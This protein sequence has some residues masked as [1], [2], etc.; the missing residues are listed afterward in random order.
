M[1]E[2]DAA[3][4]T[5]TSIIGINSRNLNTPEVDIRTF[6]R[7]APVAKDAG[8]FLVAWSGVHSRK[9]ALLVWTALMERPKRLAKISHFSLQSAGK[10]CT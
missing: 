1:Q 6:E 7:L 4:N 3:L 5:N 8:V 10:G 2:L 9:D